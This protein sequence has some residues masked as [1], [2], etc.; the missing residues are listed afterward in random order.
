MKREILFRGFVEK[1]NGDITIQLD[2][3]E[4]KGYWIYWN[5]YGDLDNSSPVSLWYY[6]AHDF[7][8]Y[9][10][11]E[12]VG[13]YT[14]LTDK[15]G[16]KVFEDDIVDFVVFDINDN[17]TSYRGVVKWSDTEQIATSFTIWHD[18]KNEYYGS[19]GAFDLGEVRYQ[20]SEFEVIGN[21]YD[22]LELLQ[23]GDKK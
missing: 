9:I 8:M 11:P 18:N 6:K 4:I 13:Q 1:S 5:E 14:G 2:G 12:T 22:N 3:R 20:D 16:K 17:D 21:I 15:N 23:G 7:K 10:I 19:D